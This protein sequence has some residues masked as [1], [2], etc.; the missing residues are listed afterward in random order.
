MVLK[1][2]KITTTAATIIPLPWSFKETTF[3]KPDI[4]IHLWH[5]PINCVIL[6]YNVSEKI[7][8]ST[9]SVTDKNGFRVSTTYEK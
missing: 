3:S 4:R 5:Q 2:G 8:N 7:K 1:E 9:E 6:F